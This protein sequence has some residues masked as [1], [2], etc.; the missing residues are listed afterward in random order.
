MKVFDTSAVIG[1]LIDR[2][3]FTLGEAYTTAG[4]VCELK[5]KESQEYYKAHSLKITLKEPSDAS[6]QRVD[7]MA[8]KLNVT[9][10]SLVDKGVV[11]LCLDLSAPPLPPTLD[12]AAE[13]WITHENIDRQ[14]FCVTNDRAM[15]CLLSSFGIQ[16]LDGL[17]DLDSFIIRCYA[18]FAQYAEQVSLC[19]KCGYNTISRVRVTRTGSETILHLSK[20][21]RGHQN[22]ETR[23]TRRLRK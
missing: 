8:A 15:K 3:D 6:L 12:I 7:R 21:F 17:R 4:V 11:A 9:G 5:D 19:K 14:L 16:T 13:G 22:R 2:C 20:S 18:C 1:R 10:L 23:S